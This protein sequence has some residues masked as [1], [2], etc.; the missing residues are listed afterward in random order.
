MK[1]KNKIEFHGG[2]AAAFIP[3][4]VFLFFCILYF[5]VYKVFEMYALCMGAFVGLLIGAV[6]TRKGYYEK[7]WNAVYEGASESVPIIILLFVIG[8]FSALVKSCNV[9]GG[10]VWLAESLGVRDGM[11]TAFTFL[12]VCIISTVTGSSI[13]SMF[14][15]FPIFY[16]AGIL[17]G[18]NAPFLAG[19]IVS[20]AVFGDMLAP[21]SDSTIISTGTQEYS[22]KE[23]IADVGGCVATRIKYAVVGGII[24]FFVYWLLGGGGM[25]SQDASEILEA[26]MNPV[27]LVMLLPVAVMLVVAIKTHDIYIASTVGIVLGTAVGL[28]TGLLTPAS[29]V[30]VTDGSPSGF[31]TDGISN[32]LS[33]A[34]LVVSVYGI[35]GVL[36]AAGAINKVTTAIAG[37]KLGETVMG[38]EIAMML[39]ITFT[40]LIFGGVTSASMAT[41]GKIQNELGKKA[42]LH[43]YRR[44]NLLVGFANSIAVCV[45]FLSCFA[46]IGALLTQGYDMVDPL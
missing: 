16:P 11:F 3:V 26:G 19:A 38:T 41:F 13:G 43:P 5:V 20:G 44:A 6:F 17:M 29:I 36:N 23:G 21:I 9:S 18:A 2:M 42:G 40:T 12:A 33:T 34:I 45:P 8:M 14:T 31:L 27:A 46:F 37:S 7:Y 28:V 10:F 30:S 32:M 39:G 25:N 4:V 1:E 15:C 35:M 24:S 22:K